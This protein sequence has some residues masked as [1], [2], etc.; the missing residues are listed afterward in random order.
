[1]IQY[2]APEKQNLE[3][4]RHDLSPSCH[5]IKV[6]G[7]NFSFFLEHQFTEA[8]L[9]AISMALIQASSSLSCPPGN[10]GLENG[11]TR[12]KVYFLVG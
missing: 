10:D 6:N 4:R 11:N 3:R 1:M 2:A 12:E 8:I 9:S 5:F 7:K